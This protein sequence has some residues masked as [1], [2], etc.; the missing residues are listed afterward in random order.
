MR[1]PVLNHEQRGRPRRRAPALL[2][3]AVPVVQQTKFG[4]PR[5]RSRKLPH[6]AAVT[7]LATVAA[8][9]VLT[10]LATLAALLPLAN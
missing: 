5:T 3:R 7:T 2:P 8:V 6:A 10:A 1:N 9:A 4:P